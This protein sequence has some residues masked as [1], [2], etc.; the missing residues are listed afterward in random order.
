LR[1]CQISKVPT[2]RRRGARLASTHLNKK[3]I[4]AL[5]KKSNPKFESNRLK[6]CQSACA[7]ETIDRE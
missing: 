7:A 1:D 6:A 4:K 2:D 3:A 5:N